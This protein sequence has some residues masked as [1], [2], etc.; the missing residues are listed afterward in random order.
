MLTLSDGLVSEINE[1]CKTNLKRKKSSA[2]TVTDVT[3]VVVK[4]EK[5]FESK[6]STNRASDGVIV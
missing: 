4:A 1:H 3:A 5:C 2:N 6:H